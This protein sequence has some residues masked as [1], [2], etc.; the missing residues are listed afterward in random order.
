MSCAGRPI[1]SYKVDT[2][3]RRNPDEFATELKQTLP[4]RFSL[5]GFDLAKLTGAVEAE[6]ARLGG[7]A[8]V[9]TEYLATV[10]A[11]VNSNDNE[12]H[13]LSFRF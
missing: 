8:L 6:E 11:A 9:T 10:A 3:A 13:S 12:V 1:H 2:E 5:N 7:L 4:M